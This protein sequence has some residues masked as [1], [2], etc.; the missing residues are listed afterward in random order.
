MSKKKNSEKRIPITG[1]EVRRRRAALLIRNTTPIPFPEFKR[2]VDAA[3]EGGYTTVCLH[4]A[5]YNAERAPLRYELAHYDRQLAYLRSCSMDAILLI[6]LQRRAHTFDGERVPYDTV[7]TTDEFAYTYGHEDPYQPHTPSDS[8]VISPSAGKAPSR[9]GRFYRDAVKHFADR[10]GR[11]VACII[12][13][14]TESLTTDLG[15]MSDYSAHAKRAFDAFLGRAYKKISHLNRDL[16]TDYKAFDDV[17]LPPPEDRGPMGILFAQF[18][19]K[20]L[21]ELITSLATA[22]K[23]AAPT[24]PFGVVLG[25]LL[26][27]SARDTGTLGFEALCKPADTVLLKNDVSRTL[28]FSLDCLM[29]TFAGKEKK[30]GC[31]LTGNERSEDAVLAYRHNASLVCMDGD[32][33]EADSPSIATAAALYLC[34][35]PAPCVAEDVD[36]GHIVD[37]STATLFS[38]HAEDYYLA[39]Y[40]LYTDGGAKF[41]RVR[42]QDD[43]QDI[44]TPH[45][46]AGRRLKKEKKRKGPEDPNAPA[47]L[48]RRKAAAAISATAAVASAILILSAGLGGKIL[49][50]SD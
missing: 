2:R 43:L 24:V 6:D 21:T 4:I 11:T 23:D 39:Y 10:H 42:V 12:P 8:L 45:S 20:V 31:I 15:P 46:V 27:S 19:Q 34:K 50:D 22:H 41:G 30:I 13:T 16:D 48:F 14:F 38:A 47:V 28:T 36:S 5:W 17:P 49:K 32:S 37:V 3:R 33:G 35:K 29:S 26:D 25:S 1:N 40:T 7:I 44:C 9:A 18:R